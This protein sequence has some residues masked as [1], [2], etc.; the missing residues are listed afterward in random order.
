MVL[1]LQ[2]KYLWMLRVVDAQ[3]SMS[4]R[5]SRLWVKTR[6]PS[7]YGPI[8]SLIEIDFLG[9]AVGT[10]TNTN[11]HGPRLRH[12]YIEL[13]GFTVGQTNSAFNSFVALDTI[14]FVINDTFVRQPLVRYSIESRELAYDI[15]FEQPESTLLDKNGTILTPKDD[16]LP[17][18]IAR[19]RYYPLWGEASL[20][21]LSRYIKQDMLKL[22]DDSIINKADWKFAWGVNLSAKIKIHELDDIRFDAQYG[23]GLGRYISYNAYP[24]GFV[25]DNGDIRLQKTF[26]GHLGYRHFWNKDLRSTLAVSFAGT[27]N[28]SDKISLLNR[29]NV[30][31]NAYSIQT[32]LLWIPIKNTSIG[33]EYAK[34]IREVESEEEGNMDILTF[35]YRF[36][37]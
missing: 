15:S 21:F 28:S 27:K 13:A 31:K 16:L 36:D 35:L 2:E 14:S 18:I 37:F 24:A 12:A 3:L 17:D 19:V 1:F 11:S 9:T 5:D 6:T 4:S 26:G 22:S 33:V 29:K 20:A 7:K 23:L 34:A 8:R 10:E 32:N 30:N 25:D